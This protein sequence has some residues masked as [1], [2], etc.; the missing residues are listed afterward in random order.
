MGRSRLISACLPFRR[1]GVGLVAALAMA[2]PTGLTAA[3]ALATPA[4]GVVSTSSWQAPPTG[5]PQEVHIV[6]QLQNNTAGNVTVSQINVVL[7]DG[8]GGTIDTGQTDA[9]VRI[10]GPGEVSPFEYVLS[11]VPANYASFAIGTISYVQATSQPY[12]QQ[13]ATALV[14]CPLGFSTDW[15]CGTVTNNGGATAAGVRAIL[16]Y[17]DGGG[18]VAQEQVMVDGGPIA[19]TASAPFEKMLAVDQPTGTTA[20]GN[21]IL[22][23]EP[24]Y[25]VEL[26]PA[27]VDFQGQNV[28]TISTVEIV[29]V[30][31]LG[32]A[33]LIVNG[34]TASGDS[35]AAEFSATSDCVST[36]GVAP[37][38]ACH[39]S[40]RFAP[41][42]AGAR[43][44]ALTVTDNAAGSARTIPL[45]GR[46]TLPQIAFSSS[47][48]LTARGGTTSSAQPIT[49]S[50]AGDG[51][52]TI[53]SIV[54]D[55]PSLF[56]VVDPS[57]CLR[58]VAAGGH[59]Q[60]SVTFS[61]PMG[62]PYDG[63]LVVH[64]NV[65]PGTHQLALHGA[66]TGPAAV[67]N[68]PAV[69]F[70]RV[71]IG[72][73]SAPTTVT[74]TN[75][76][77]EDLLITGETIAG[78]FAAGAPVF[79]GCPPSLLNPAI[80]V[81][82]A[83]GTCQL[84]LTFGPHHAGPQAGSLTIAD[85]AANGTQQ[86]TLNGTGVTPQTLRDWLRVTPNP[87]AGTPPRGIRY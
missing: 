54:V 15:V 55:Q 1:L 74:L 52:L 50:N 57:Q 77:T 83:G 26:N 78:E 16:T 14:H 17:V 8:N 2:V 67:F 34:V 28:G 11:P 18:I 86:L 39:V 23:A 84:T 30:R 6:G 45:M 70:G 36:A 40:V 43:T 69:D 5:T 41:S 72:G 76:G 38:G 7:K 60:V 71:L 82:R 48:A 25:Q 61:P 66:G 31:N 4:I 20:P 22:M 19:P 58:G 63:N 56:G 3:H 53:S 9:A 59:C 51:P 65:A 29:T 64:D 12:H 37:G 27:S 24:D 62:G 87:V 75:N 21:P 13:L 47:P 46:G 85:N 10:L 35:S 49:I 44:G 32:V 79:A 81:V 73:T 42:A 68:P 80:A 33:P